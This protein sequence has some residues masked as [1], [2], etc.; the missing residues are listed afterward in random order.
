MLMRRFTWLK[1]YVMVSTTV[2]GLEDYKTRFV[3]GFS[4]VMDFKVMLMMCRVKAYKMYMG[5]YMGKLIMIAILMVVEWGCVYINDLF[6]TK[7]EF[8]Y[9]GFSA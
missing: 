7:F 4:M 1:I 8:V 3:W 9:R 2:P 5:T 6:Q